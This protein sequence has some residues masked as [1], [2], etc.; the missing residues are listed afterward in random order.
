MGERYR[1][2]IVCFCVVLCLLSAFVEPSTPLQQKA[3]EL[4]TKATAEDKAGNFEEAL[5][6][7]ENAVQYFLHAMKCKRFSAFFLCPVSMDMAE[8]DRDVLH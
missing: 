2:G 3:I 1:Q 6:L 8:S 4:V 5:Q 7:Y